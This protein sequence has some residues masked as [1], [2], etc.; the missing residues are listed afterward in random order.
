MTKVFPDT[1]QVVLQE[2]KALLTLCSGEK[3]FLMQFEIIRPILEAAQKK[4]KPRK[5]DQYDVFC[6]LLYLLKSGCQWRMLPSDFPQWKLVHY[7]FTVWSWK[8]N[9]N[10]SSVLEE[11]LKKIGWSRT[12]EKWEKMQNEYGYR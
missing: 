4:T 5:I 1:L 3:C 9:K 11:V 12:Y 2:R 6:A 7:Y 8:K 10:A